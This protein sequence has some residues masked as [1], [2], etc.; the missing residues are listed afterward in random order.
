MKVVSTLT[1]SA[2]MLAAGITTSNAWLTA[3][4]VFCDANQNEQID[5]NDR[6]IPGVL[7]V[8]VNTSGTYSNATWT[9]TP[10]AAFVLALPD[11]SDSYIEYLHPS[12]LP[13]DAASTVPPTGVYTFTLTDAQNTFSGDFLINSST[14]T[15]VQ[16]PT[17]S[18]GCWLT[19]GGT[20]G[21]GKGIPEH[22]FGGVVY[23]GCKSSSA[24]GGN[25]NDV[26]HNLK[27]HFKGLNIVVVDCGNVPGIPPGSKSPKT[28]FNFI[29]FQ[30]VGT[31]KG[32]GGNTADY[33][34]VYFF[35]RAEDRAEPG[36]G[37]D[38]YYLRVYDANGNT[39]MLVSADPANPLDVAPVPIATGNLQIHSSGCDKKLKV[40]R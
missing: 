13:S 22:S 18:G 35:A 14:C 29:E 34:V 30:G 1:V 26:A 39:L 27:L 12:T 20:I 5:A 19:G 23:P 36:K 4:H 16:P 7:V 24:G 15:N 10:D 28:P 31:L 37:I 25:W 9:S 6:P 3:G 32:I 2:L 11:A 17:T 8:V 33:G 40:A 38:R 21:A